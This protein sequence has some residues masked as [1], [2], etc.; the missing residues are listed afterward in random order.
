MRPRSPKPYK[1]L[2]IDRFILH[3]EEYARNLRSL[4]RMVDV[5]EEMGRGGSAGQPSRRAPEAGAQRLPA[6]P[7]TTIHGGTIS[8]SQRQL[9]G[10]VA[11]H[12]AAVPLVSSD[13][14]WV[15]AEGGRH[16][17]SQGQ[18]GMLKAGLA[19][20]CRPGIVNLFVV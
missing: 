16:G 2:P 4:V 9:Q 20:E 14:C 13:C 8:S 1:L 15:E 11:H 12:R 10:V 5:I 6:V 3:R 7:S 18:G 19:A 17:A